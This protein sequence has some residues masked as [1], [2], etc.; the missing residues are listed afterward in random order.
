MKNIV[1]FIFISVFICMGSLVMSSFL[2]IE[3]P[4]KPHFKFPY[5]QAGLTKREAAAHL[6]N[7]FT[8]GA[9]PDQVDEI[10]KMGLEKWFESQLN[11]G[12]PDDS[13]DARL[14]TYDALKL[15]NTEVLNMFPK[16]G[17]ILRMAVRD[18]LINKDSINKSDRADYK[19]KLAAYMKLKGLRP[20]QELLNQ[21]INQKILRATYSNNQLQEVLTDFWF[22]HF[23]VSIVKNDCAQFIPAYERDV[24]RPNVT[25][26]FEDLLLATAK[27]PAMLY[28]LDNF[29]SAGTNTPM[30]QPGAEQFR[31]KG[32]AQI[33]GIDDKQKAQVMKKIQQGKANQGLNENYAREVMEL[34]T[35]GVDGGYTQQDVTQAARVLTGWTIYPIGD[36]FNAGVAKK[37]IESIGEDK[38]KERGFVHDGDFLFAV[39]RHDNNE[40]TVLGKT[41]AANGEYEE[42]V[43]LLKML[44][45]HP[46][47]A[48]FISTKIAVHFVC[49]NPPKGLID[50]MAKTFMDKDGDIK[51]V[52]ITMVSSPEFWSKESLREKIKSPFELAISAVRCLHANIVAPV[53]L[54]NWVTKMGQKEYYYQAPTGYP[55]N[56]QYWINTGSLLNRMNFGLALVLGRIPGVTVDFIALNKYHEPEGAEAAL[57]TY[58]KLMMPERNLDETEKRLK[59][60]LKD[61]GLVK[62]VDEAASKTGNKQSPV[63]TE[64]SNS[65]MDNNMMGEG[66]DKPEK[67]QTDKKNVSNITALAIH[68]VVG[69]NPVLAQVVGILIGSPEFQ[70]K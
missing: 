20:E 2:A 30:K 61:P 16:Q 68:R 63:A 31:K 40:K 48:R 26:K 1:K 51:E 41:F 12:L 56:G 6:L 15:S 34:H 64:N 37:F 47:T 27:S 29:S 70:R 23:N 66:N 52:L 65:M 4:V 3:T 67:K 38:L 9:T 7:R 50:K 57:V 14:S 25:G 32:E 55:D 69:S 19:Q 43:T 10:V 60:L 22:N 13:L 33:S 54:N 8:F 45:H 21:F 28:Y 24:I 62:K 53:Q 39:N 46:S 58:G 5:K 59:P 11:A 42:G 17:Q 49:D 18:S 35:L 44:A 36:Y